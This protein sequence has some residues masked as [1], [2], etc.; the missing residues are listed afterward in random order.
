MN[1]LFTR[2]KKQHGFSLVELLVVITV[3]AILVSISLN[4]TKGSLTSVEISTSAGEVATIF[5]RAKEEALIRNANV[6]VRIYETEDEDFGERAYN[7][8]GIG[9]IE[10]PDDVSDVN[11]E[12]LEFT[13]LARRYRIPSSVYLMDTAPH[14]TM[15]TDAF[16]GVENDDELGS[17]NYSAITFSPNSRTS[18]SA[19]EQWTLTFIP[20]GE[21][22][23][24]L[25]KNF[26]TLQLYPSTG[27]VNIIEP[28]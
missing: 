17:L 23:N 4:M 16:E 7:L 22:L 11:V 25:P 13:Q 15:I 14:S 12:D 20:N 26:I 10:T 24:N 21:N 6:Q 9:M 2:K 19:D 28:N 8:V 27:R 18:L 5:N 3:V 1:F